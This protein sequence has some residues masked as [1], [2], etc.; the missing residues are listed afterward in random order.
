[1]TET[2]PRI[3]AHHHLWRLADRAGQWPPPALAA[4]HRDFTLDDLAPL[5]AAA[6]IDGT[7]LVQTL[8]DEA[9]T[10]AMLALAARAPVIRGVV[11]WTDLTA[12][13][14]PEKIAR[15]ARDPHL[16]GLRPMLQDHPDDAWIADPA[17]A[18][19][20]DAMVAHGLAFDA[21]VRPRQLGSLLTFALRHPDLRIV[22]DHGAK[23]EIG[24]G[25]TPGWREAMAALAARPNVW[26]KLSGLLTEAGEGG[27]EAVRP[28]AEA[29]LDLFGPARVLWGSDWPVLNLAGAYGD[30][31]DA[32]RALVPP[33]HHDAVFGGNAVSFYRLGRA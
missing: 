13:D 4:I 6:G 33:A 32:C 29:I 7:V 2:A 17:L 11:G 31:L 28:Y 3:D 24:A 15:L 20:I 14:A 12:P 1:M 26:C 18:P 22:V 19:A 27:T 30:W 16:K 9:E 5:L 21:L 23:P 8:E 25:G 10:A